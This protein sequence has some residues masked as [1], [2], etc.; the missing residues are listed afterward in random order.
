MYDD[1]IDAVSY[2]LIFDYLPFNNYIINFVSTNSLTFFAMLGL[3]V[4]IR[5]LKDVFNSI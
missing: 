3:M 2:D 5:I 4:G 1:I